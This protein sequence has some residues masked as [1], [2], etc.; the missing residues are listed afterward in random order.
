MQSPIPKPQDPGVE[1]KVTQGDQ[2]TEGGPGQ[3]MNSPDY[4]AVADRVLGEFL[5]VKCRKTVSSMAERKAGEHML[6]ARDAIFSRRCPVAKHAQDSL[7]K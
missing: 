4:S 5:P 3:D 1:K 2:R 6:A 7:G